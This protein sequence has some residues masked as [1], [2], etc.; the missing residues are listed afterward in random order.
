VTESTGAQAVRW[1]GAIIGFVLFGACAAFASFAGVMLVFVSDSCGSAG[2]CRTGLIM[3]GMAVTGIGPWLV[4]LVALVIAVV[5]GRRGRPVVWVPW[6]GL[7]AA[8]AVAVGGIALA[9]AGAP[10]GF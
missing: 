4:F 6:I 1:A 5:R 7:I 8:A 3:A 10:P 2:E 9:F